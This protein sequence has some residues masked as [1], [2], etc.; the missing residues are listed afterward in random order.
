MSFLIATHPLADAFLT[1][2][3]AVLEEQPRLLDVAE[4]S[5]LPPWSLARKLVSLRHARCLIPVQNEGGFALLPVLMTLAA[6]TFPRSVAIVHPDLRIEEVSRARL[7]AAAGQVSRASLEVFIAVRR[8]RRALHELA[9]LPR[10]EL[11]VGAGTR[12]LYLNANLW[13]G[14]AVGGS[15][16]HVAGVINGMVRA[17][18]E[19]DFLSA[20]EPILID[21]RVSFKRLDTGVTGL[22][23][24]GNYYRLNHSIAQQ[25]SRWGATNAHRFIYQ[26]MS[27][28]NTA[29]AIVSRSRGIPLVIEYNGSE[30]WVAR[31]WGRQ[32]RYEALARKAE[33]VCLTHAHLVV[34]VSEVLRDE[35][36]ARGVERDRIVVYPNCVDPAMFDPGLYG[37]RERLELRRALGI[38][39]DA[40][41]GTFLGTF[42]HWHGVDVLARAIRSMIDRHAEW[43]RARGVRFL[44]IGDG[45]KRQE[46]KRALVG[47]G[48]DEF[49]VMAGLIPQKEA[50]RYLATSDFLYSPHVPNP[51][52]SPFFG[53]PTKLFEYMIMGRPIIASRLEQIGEVLQPALAVEELPARAPG[54]RDAPLAVLAEPG[55][56]DGIVRGTQFLVDREDW[57]RRIGRS[58]RAEALARY[59]WDHHVSAILRGVSARLSPELV[60]HGHSR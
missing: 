17:G 22:P 50:P 10:A 31:H 36:L 5:R 19:I 11:S 33:E 56:P 49:V 32:L 8:A 39:E 21:G 7:V 18:H 25:A 46:V 54:S 6:V 51:D 26:R 30:V 47:P 13:S 34:T 29:G 28:G 9:R 45:L 2:V 37:E 16:G 53:S 24:E 55:D 59:T 60:G 57:R 15:V 43:L 3:E 35:L 20:A 44:L 27:L 48:T 14:L 52:G 42:G 38:P 1:R 4:L 40:L 12:C 58:S 23:V 41:V